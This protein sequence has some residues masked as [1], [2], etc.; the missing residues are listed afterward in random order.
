MKR[1]VIVGGGI[2]GL[3]AAHVLEQCGRVPRVDVRLLEASERLGGKIRSERIDGCVLE[4]GPDMFVTRKP[5]LM[6]LCETLAVAIQPPRTGP[7]RTSVMRDGRLHPLP[8]GFTGI[9]P[10]R[11]LALLRTGLLSGR[12]RARALLEPLVPAWR[13]G[14]TS[15]RRFLSRRFGAEAYEWLIAPML[16]GVYGE[17]DTLSTEA[18]LPD[19]RALE[20]RHGSITRGLR[21][22]RRADVQDGIAAIPFAS[23]ND[24]M[25][26]IIGALSARLTTVAIHAHTPVR[27]IERTGSAYTIVRDGSP[28]EADAV[29]LALPSNRAAP[30][31]AAL[32]PALG[33]ALDAIPHESVATAILAYEGRDVPRRADAYG[34][35]IPASEGRPVRAVTCVTDKFEGRAPADT[36]VFRVFFGAADAVDR[37]DDELLRDAV[38]EL[39]RTLDVRAAP[40]LSRIVRWPDGL[41]RY[42][43]GHSQRVAAV[44]DALRA[45][46]GLFIAGPSLHGAGL[47]DCVRTAGAA[48]RDA[49]AYIES[50]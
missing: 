44:A 30:I 39:A 12:G 8:D 34:W 14:D 43:L 35:L 25:E 26:S 1:V 37:S 3:A 9:V 20:R 27:R 13:G 6:R 17:G 42:T 16:A 2:S 49:L 36:P 22:R 33:A 19:L 28:L 48:A 5:E 40:R 41:P 11:P 10:G 18:T 45:L 50:S 21:A 7:R 29:I 15:V 32:H 38:G 46:P 47:P 23:A 31:V 24:G 4:H